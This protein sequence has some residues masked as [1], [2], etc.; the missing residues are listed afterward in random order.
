MATAFHHVL[1]GGALLLTGLPSAAQSTDPTGVFTGR[2]ARAATF[3]NQKVRAAVRL[4][5]GWLS[6]HQEADGHWDAAGF[7]RHD[8]ATDRCDGPGNGTYDVGIT[9]L[10]LLA[11]LAPADP[12]KEEACRLAA[13]WLANQFDPTT[14]RVQ[15]PNHDFIYQHA[16]A[17]AALA[18]AAALLGRP[19]YRD[20]AA[21]GLAYL[22]AHRNP[23][24][25]W[26]YAAQGGDNDS[27]VTSWCLVAI[28]SCRHLGLEVDAD[29]IGQ[30]LAWLDSI[31]DATTGH[32][33]YGRRGEPSARNAGDHGNRFPPELGATLTAA[34][35]HA[36]LLCG[37]NPN[38]TLVQGAIRLLLERPPAWTPPTI[39]YFGWLHGSTAV[40]NLPAS[41][42]ARRWEN[43]L[44]NVLVANQCQ[45]GAAK[46]SWD[47]I[48][49]WGHVGGRV[50]A[51]ACA[52]LGLAAPWRLGRMDALASI[53]DAAPFQKV[54]QHW[55]GGR[56]G[57]AAVELAAVPEDAA[58]DERCRWIRW[59][60]DVEVERA[61]TQQLALGT[62]LPN[63]LDRLEHL[64]RTAT[65]LAPLA[66][67]DQARR[68]VAALQAD[69][70]TVDE[71]TAGRQL[72]VVR[73]LYDEAIE[74]RD[75]KKRAEV[76]KLLTE[77]VEKWPYTQ[78]AHAAV[79]LAETLHGH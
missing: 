38:D 74:Q 23:G 73:K 3:G 48:D 15:C 35:L 75:P 40:A 9:A 22:L 66:V 58:T 61:L 63:A 64:E 8:P 37:A 13:D 6:S 20:A 57:A 60:L 55:L 70:A 49:V 47:P 14:G 77:L 71:I 72:R 4:G 53:P 5:V 17:T 42:L 16:L 45:K 1:L 11:L 18:E 28:A 7:M 44:Q 67:A 21:Q 65:A 39:D 43:T 12:G 29:P 78:A 10:A 30:S 41:T 2:A 79:K 46:G 59:Y 76:R 24:S 69:P 26:R 25:A 27:S 34:S 56:L 19:R 68:L 50:Y 36:R 54:R 33:G 62:M 52:V 51:T 31:T 32:C